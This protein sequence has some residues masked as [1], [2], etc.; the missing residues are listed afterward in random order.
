MRTGGAGGDLLV[1]QNI[2]HHP[3]DGEVP[4]DTY[5]HMFTDGM[6]FRAG[7]T[8]MIQIYGSDASGSQNFIG[9]LV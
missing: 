4:S 3:G 8:N 9:L 6:A 7:S 5:F 1:A 2:R